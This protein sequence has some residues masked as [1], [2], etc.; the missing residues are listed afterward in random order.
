MTP[1]LRAFLATSFAKKPMLSDTQR[2]ETKDADGMVIHGFEYDDGWYVMA[3]EEPRGRAKA[4]CGFASYM[5]ATVAFEANDPY[6]PEG[7]WIVECQGEVEYVQ[8]S[9]LRTLSLTLR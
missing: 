4:G 5:R 7:T 6:E 1:A 2:F 3:Q 8:A 9:Q